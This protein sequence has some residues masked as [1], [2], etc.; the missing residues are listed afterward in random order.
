MTRLRIGLTGMAVVIVAAVA[1]IVTT[2]G[3]SART[4]PTT[5]MASISVANTSLG[6][7]LAG[8]NGRTVYLFEGD[9][10]ELSTLSAAGRAVWPPVTASVRTR[11]AGGARAADIGIINGADGTHQVTY[12]GRPLYYFVGDQ[13]SAQTNGQGLNE[14]GARWYVLS[15]AGAA[16]TSKIASKSGGSASQTATGSGSSYAY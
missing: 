8:P 3:G 7:V 2:T 10:H 11:A 9:K 16:I 14:F 13:R 4:P 6:R 5:P 12:N 15:P 1:A